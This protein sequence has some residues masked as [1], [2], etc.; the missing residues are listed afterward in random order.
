MMECYCD[1]VTCVHTSK[2]SK[3]SPLNTCGF[4]Y[5]CVSGKLYEVFLSGTQT[6]RC[7]LHICSRLPTKQ[8]FEG[9]V[10][11]CC[12]LLKTLLCLERSP[13]SPPV[14]PQ[15][16]LDLTLGHLSGTQF[17]GFTAHSLTLLA[18]SA[19]WS[20]EGPKQAPRPES[21]YQPPLMRL[22]APPLAPGSLCSKVPC[23]C[24]LSDTPFVTHSPPPSLCLLAAQGAG[25]HPTS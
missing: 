15:S 5:P 14:A 12:F 3:S 7:L 20:L 25:H 9:R 11:P 4:A 18:T 17:L 23:L 16:P 8:P 24:G 21:L 13:P 6:A 2:I 19:S 1:G 10:R 22:P